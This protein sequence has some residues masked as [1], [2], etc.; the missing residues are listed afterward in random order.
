MDAKKDK[1]YE[2]EVF[3][4]ANVQ[5]TQEHLA[6]Q[7]ANFDLFGSSATTQMSLIQQSM[8]TFFKIVDNKLSSVMKLGSF[9]HEESM[10]FYN[11]MRI[12]IEKC[13]QPTEASAAHTLSDEIDPTSSPP[14]SEE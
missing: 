9:N 13:S 8:S 5:A 10:Q 12:Q 4:R 2:E 3:W 7:D 6:S 1:R 11:D 14:C